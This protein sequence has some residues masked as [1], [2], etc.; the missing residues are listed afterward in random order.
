MKLGEDDGWKVV[1]R[2]G[3]RRPDGVSSEAPLP[4][5]AGTRRMAPRSAMDIPQTRASMAKMAYSRKLISERNQVEM[6][7][8]LHRQQLMNNRRA[9]EVF[10]LRILDFELYRLPNSIRFI[11]T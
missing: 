5:E 6:K 11:E 3:R 1:S 4:G 8:K 7:E 10:D 9:G 2:K